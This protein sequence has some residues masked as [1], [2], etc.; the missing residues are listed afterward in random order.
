M[1]CIRLM[2]HS[3][4]RKERRLCFIRE[5]TTMVFEF[6]KKGDECIYVIEFSLKISVFLKLVKN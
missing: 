1:L 5:S 3:I 6:K 2:D 4:Q